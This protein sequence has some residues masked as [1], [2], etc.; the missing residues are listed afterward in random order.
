[1]RLKNADLHTDCGQNMMRHY[2]S[3]TED[4]DG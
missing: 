1:M 3:G 2:D 4:K